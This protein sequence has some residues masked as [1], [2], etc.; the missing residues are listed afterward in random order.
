MCSDAAGRVMS[1]KI[2]RQS[3]QGYLLLADISGY[4]AFLT[5]TELEHA[6]E[7]V[8]ELTTLIRERLAPP[9]RFVK[10]E[11]DAVFCYAD[12]ATLREGERLVELIEAC[13]FEFSNRLLDMARATT[14]RCK[15]CAAIDSLGLKFVTHYGSY[16]IERDDGRDDLTGPD[17]IL[18]HRL[19]K[20]TIS[21][22]G[23]PQAYA[24]L[25]EACLQRM[26]RPFNLPVHREV[27]ES[28]G[29][30]KGGVH[31]LQPVLSAMRE[32]RRVYISAAEADV[33]N[34]YDLA[35]PPEVA[36]Q[37]IVDPIERQR[38]ACRQFSKD[39]DEEQLNAQGRHGAG[40]KVHCG[41][42]P[43][44]V[45]GFREVI[46]WRPFEYFTARTMTPVAGA[47]LRPRPATETVEF[48]RLGEHSTRV[49]W[50]FRLTNRSRVSL[51]TLRAFRPFW[52]AFWRRAN[53]ALVGIIEEDAAA[54][55]V[56]TAE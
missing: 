43:G 24:F 16:V 13:Y 1:P 12:A 17:V 11:G 15:A 47:F 3:E 28:F 36:W 29:E 41:H 18:A 10:L 50:R 37:Y 31:D 48:E 44:P 40:T 4:T 5:G 6:H 25:T 33:E 38:W 54:Q 51:L 9:M 42:G 21:E 27:Y 8:H 2:D 49:I 14:C 22:G 53:G 55:S 7:I 35:I 32:E 34:T 30:T 26:P 39:P 45:W 56:R 52:L 46:D 20:N 19:L 23:G